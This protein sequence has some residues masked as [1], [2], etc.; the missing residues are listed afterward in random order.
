MNLTLNDPTLLRFQAL[1]AG[2][3]I[4]ADSGKRFT[5]FNPANGQP[6]AE[7]PDLGR[8]ETCRAISA[9]EVAQKSWARLP[10]KERA[11]IIHTWYTLILE[12]AEDLGKILTAEQGK[13]LTEA[14]GEIRYA[15]GF[16]EWFS[17]EAKRLYGEIIPAPSGHQRISVIR[18]PVGVT[19]AI[20]PWNFPSAMLARKV[21]PALAAGCSMVIKPA[22]ETPLSALAMAELGLRAG[23]PAGLLSIIT[24][25]RSAEVGLEFCEN[26]VVRTLSFTG[27]TQ[28][29]KLLMQQAA[30]TVKKLSLELGGNAPFI[31]FD[32]ANLDAAV[33]G[34]VAAKFRNAGQACVSANRILVQDTVYEA[35]AE[36]FAAAI[37]ALKVGEG[38][39]TDS[40]IGP[41]ID[42]R[43][44]EKIEEHI[45]E[46]VADGATITLGGKRHALGGSFFEPTLITGV[47]ARMR[48]ACE[49]TF[50]PVAALL[51]FSS[52]EEAIQLANDTPFGLAAYFYSRDIGRITRVSE[53]LEY[54]M[55]GINEGLISTEVAPFGGVKESGLGREGSHHGIDEYV[56]LKYVML[57]GLDD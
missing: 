8:A 21:A 2:T 53:A 14:V 34:A 40:Q 37:A 50:G 31:I 48:L 16:L 47:D 36:R 7:V 57:G 12:H 42:I 39:A 46:A 55:V 27:S 13:P 10:A 5:V 32:D 1:V 54:G 51:P 19:A 29:G 35:F 11:Q 38:T 28:V 33:K 23:I 43:A 26:P 20:T 6:L 9:A 45:Q 17:E 44:L 30:S 25:K 24:S 22:S 41:L 3:W 15:A 49:E 56:E 52:E 4:E 18:Q